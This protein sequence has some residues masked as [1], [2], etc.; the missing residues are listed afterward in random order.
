MVLI[1][2]SGYTHSQPYTPSCF[3]KLHCMAHM[4]KN[5]I[6]THVTVGPVEAIYGLPSILLY[7][8]AMCIFIYLRFL[9]PY[10]Y[11]KS[12]FSVT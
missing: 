8:E 2:A 7:A 11:F 3:L 6:D 1:L 12:E 10:T 9:N 5:P 4:S